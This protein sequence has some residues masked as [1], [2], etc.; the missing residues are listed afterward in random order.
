MV[1]RIQ[2]I[3][4]LKHYFLLVNNSIRNAPLK[5]EKG[6]GCIGCTDHFTVCSA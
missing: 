3:M 4:L 1:L 2:N 6:L 5:E